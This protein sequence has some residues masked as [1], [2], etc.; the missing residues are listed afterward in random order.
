MMAKKRKTKAKRR[1]R[2]GTQVEAAPFK[3]Y[4]YNKV[5]IQVG[6][7]SEDIISQLNALGLQ[8]W[9]AYHAFEAGGFYQF[10]FTREVQ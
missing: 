6:T 3:M 10:L 1:P 7:S 2:M 4:E 8:G 9:L 5:D